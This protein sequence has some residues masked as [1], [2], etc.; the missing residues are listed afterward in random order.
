M[1]R[2]SAEIM[3]Q[4]KRILWVLT[5]PFTSV[6]TLAEGVWALWTNDGKRWSWHAGERYAERLFG[7]EKPA[8]FGADPAGLRPIP[9]DPFIAELRNPQCT[10]R[11]AH[12]EDCPMVYRP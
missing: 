9:I 3:W 1:S 12:T 4:A 10:C 7:Q 8:V 2:R 11:G 6:A 5:F